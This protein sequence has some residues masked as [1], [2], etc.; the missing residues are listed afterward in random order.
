M[1]LLELETRLR[2]WLSGRYVATLFA[3]DRVTVAY[4]LWRDDAEWVYL[5]QFFVA[6][7]VRREGIGREAIA[8]LTDE[9]WPPGKRVRVEVL[10]GNEVGLAF[11]RAIGFRD[12]FLTLEMERRE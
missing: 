11:W 10:L 1:S 12:Y 7:P 4:A 5:R 9:V 3:R 8:L 2:K 6:R